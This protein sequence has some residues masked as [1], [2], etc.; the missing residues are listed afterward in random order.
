MRN[1]TLFY[2]YSLSWVSKV[3]VRVRFQLYFDIVSLYH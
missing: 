3:R 2:S 1:M